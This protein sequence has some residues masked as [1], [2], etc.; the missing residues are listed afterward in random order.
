M[1]LIFDLNWRLYIY[2]EKVTKRPLIPMARPGGRIDKKKGLKT[3]ER[4]QWLT[5]KELK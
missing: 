5:I 3:L 2:F 1:N 4:R